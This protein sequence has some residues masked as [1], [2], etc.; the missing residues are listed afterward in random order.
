M[1]LES[2]YVSANLNHWIDLVMLT[3]L[4]V[5]LGSCRFRVQSSDWILVSLGFGFS[6]QTGL[7]L[8]IRLGFNQTGV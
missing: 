1:A 4:I 3:G 7:G 2:D 8:V 5:G 6:N